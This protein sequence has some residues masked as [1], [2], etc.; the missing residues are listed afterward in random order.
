MAVYINHHFSSLLPLSLLLLHFF[1]TTLFHSSFPAILPS[2]LHLC[3]PLVFPSCAYFPPSLFFPS[4]IFLLLPLLSS[5]FY[6][7]FLP[8]TRALYFF[9]LPS[10]LSSFLPFL[11]FHFSLSPWILYP[12]FFLP[13]SLH[14]LPASAIL[15]C[16][17][18]MSRCP[19]MSEF[20]LSVIS[21]VP[22][23]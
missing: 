13:F 1:I 3:F 19:V 12:F 14:C 5:F 20:P 2:L 6:F 7:S 17:S 21:F 16:P 18:V 15:C 10:F 23:L 11:S 4:N 22:V 9:I 8:T